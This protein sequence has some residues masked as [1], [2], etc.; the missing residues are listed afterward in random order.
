M[1]ANFRTGTKVLGGFG[2]AIVIV[3][4]VG[5]V[6]RLGIDNL[7][8]DVEE[9]GFERLPG[10][11][12]LQQIKLGGEQV[13]SAQRTLLNLDLAPDIYKRQFELIG[14]ARESYG[15]A[16]K[17]YESLPQTPEENQLWTQ[18]SA[19]W[20]AWRAANNDYFRTINDLHAL[21]AGNPD[22]LNESMQRFLAGHYKVLRDVLELLHDQQAMEGGD[23]HTK[24]PFGVW[25]SQ[26]NAGNADIL[27]C[28]TACDE[29]HRKFHEAVKKIKEL[30][31]TG[32]A[33]LA[34]KV[35]QEE[36]KPASEGIV[37]QLRKMSEVANKAQE[38]V[39]KA[40]AQAMGPCRENQ[41]KANDL[42]DQLILINGDAAHVTT[43][44]AMSDS[45]ASLMLMYVVSAAGIA[46]MAL[47]GVVL[48]RNISKVLRNLI[49]EAKRLSMAAVEGKLQTRGNPELVSLEFRPIV[50]GRQ[51]HARR[52]HRAAQRHGRIRRPHLQG[53]HPGQDHR[54]LQRRFQRDQEQPERLHRRHQRHWPATPTCWSR[55]PWT[56]T[57]PPA[58]TRPS[59]RATSARSCRA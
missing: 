54:H 50:D 16:W 24:C 23:D 10:V 25:R 22:R 46:V 42:L 2:F 12:A 3:L 37:V 30:T 59:T 39:A 36:I 33:E 43:Q 1:F 49:G 14:K 29:P 47:L 40:N 19:A 32:N 31:A 20:Q 52:G 48:A 38:M 6:G 21:Q 17:L 26:Q 13:K 5:Y 53:R 18:F 41:L 45:T 51:R 28:L 15:E 9:I 56:A 44:Q 34:E 4:V 58:P 8:K 57:W 7:T 11:S 55:Q 27:A 35:F